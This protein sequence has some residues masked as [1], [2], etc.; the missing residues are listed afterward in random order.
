MNNFLL[1]RACLHGGGKP[2]LFNPVKKKEKF[3]KSKQENEKIL[4]AL[5]LVIVEFE[6]YPNTDFEATATMLETLAVRIEVIESIIKYMNYSKKA[7]LFNM[8]DFFVS[9]TNKR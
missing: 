5:Y 3:T 6:E 8:D 1:T 7:S 9:K 2:L 4:D